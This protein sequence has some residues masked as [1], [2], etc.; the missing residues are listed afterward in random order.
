MTTADSASAAKPRY[1]YATRLNSF[2]SAA[3]GSLP[4]L[5]RAAA[6]V[7]GVTA[8]EINYPQH[9]GGLGEGEFE[10]IVAGSS[11]QPTALSLRF[12]DP[13][14]AQGAFT[15][16]APEVRER[17]IRLA[18]E[19]VALAGR[20]GVPHVNLWMATDDF[21]YPF[22]VDSPRLS[23]PTVSPRASV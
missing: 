6:A 22:A 17:A 23:C 19:A 8:V 9:L 13:A 11:L 14:F 3:G 5:L 20:L 15:N 16:P 21:D 10:A 4:E 1:R 12:D 2:R 7:P 18:Q